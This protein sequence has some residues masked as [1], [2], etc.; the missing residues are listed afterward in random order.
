MKDIFFTMN[1]LEAIKTEIRGLNSKNFKSSGQDVV[2]RM[3]HHLERLR[4]R[5]L[6]TNHTNYKIYY[7]LCDP[8]TYINAYSKVSKNFGALSKGIPED[9]EI[10]KF[11]SIR[12]AEKIA[13]KFKTKS[14]TWKPTRRTWIPK[15]GKKKMRPIDT[16][17]QED[18][19]VQEAIRGILECIF[20]P[21]FLEFE[22]QNKKICTNYGFRENKST[23]NAVEVLKI[24]GQS[25]NYGIEGDISGA[26]N[27]VDHDI[28]LQRINVRIKDKAFIK[29]ISKLLKSGVMEE[30]KI[31][32]NIKGTPQGGIVSPLLFNIYMFQLDKYIYNHIM[33]DV[34]AQNDIK[35]IRQ[36]PAHTKISREIKL[37]Y[38][39]MKVLKNQND[40][41]YRRK[42][43]ILNQ[44]ILKRSQMDSKIL[45]TLPKRAV[46]SRYADD[47]VLLISGTKEE[48]NRY[49][50]SIEKFI[51]EELK[52]VLDKEKTL[53]THI[54]DGINFLGY[55]LKM[56]KKNQK[57]LKKVLI[58]RAG[59]FSRTTKVTTSRKINIFP[60]KSRL[61][62]MLKLHKYCDSQF[63][64]KGLPGW[65]QIDEYHI[66][67]KYR[68]I[69]VGLYNYY[70]KCDN[71][72]ILY[73]ISYILKFS[74][75]KTLALRKR[76][77]MSKIFAQYG[78][79]LKITKETYLDN[80]RKLDFVEFPNLPELR[81]KRPATNTLL[82][83]S[84]PFKVSQNW[85]TSVKLF[86]NCCICGS[87]D[88]IAMHHTNSLRKVKLK[89]RN[90][91]NYVMSSLNRK[92]IPV[93]KKCHD[94]ITYGRYDKTKPI[95]LYNTFLNKLL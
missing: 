12:D 52:M 79:N 66:V 88:N 82:Q 53:I 89:E 49:K 33:M 65:G 22:S 30:G 59:K 81:S 37:T 45:A 72:Y 17:T 69:F 27:N 29:V 63:F 85:R 91:Y 61:L 1:K 26:Y 84:D 86:L 58:Y 51:K 3:A 56:Y 20:E 35:K 42:K 57:K 14:Y 67:L 62:S 6:N 44:L 92:Q 7:L 23:W 71:L 76:R 83:D 28:L 95:K 18:R 64:P 68:Q 73:R 50:E 4:L 19:I 93:C 21:E 87:D 77:S 34:T 16:P 8:F 5:N 47:W 80:Q 38:N 2:L 24:Y 78:K 13:N 41:E 15:P 10:M 48:A 39:E 31:I 55:T 32:D 40:L 94:D 90:S 43:K 36:N 11:F 46:Y 54:N 25:T 9:E 60:D 75:A 74:C 70:N